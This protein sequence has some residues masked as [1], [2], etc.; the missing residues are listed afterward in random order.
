[1]HPTSK[2]LPSPLHTILILKSFLI[3]TLLS[4]AFGLQA[5]KPWPLERAQL[6]YNGQSWIA[7]ANYIPARDINTLE[8]WQKKTFSTKVVDKEFK[9]A[10]DIGFNTMRV[11]LAYIPWKENPAAFYKR[12]DKFLAI[13]AEHYIR[14]IFVLFD[15]CWD[16]NPKPGRQPKPRPGVHNS[17]W[18]QCPGKYILGDTAR[19]ALLKPYVEGVIRHFRNDDRILMWDLYNEPGNTNANSYGDT[20]LKNKPAYSLILLK[21]VFG[22]ARDSKPTQPLTAGIWQSSDGNLDELSPIDSCSFA[23]S[24]I[25]TFHC[26]SDTTGTERLVRGLRKSGRPMVCTEYMAR[27]VGSTFEDVMP[28]LK[29][30]NVG[31]I[32]WGFVSGKSQTIYPWDSW[33]NAY[34]NEPAVWFHDIFRSNLKPYNQKETDFIRCLIK[35]T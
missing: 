28:L 25:L 23:N 17:G 30:F 24:D 22:W 32:N 1:M 35:G 6:W 31:A 33:T 26:Y 7:G 5:Q 12:M 27:P 20:E 16:P 18:V 4:L 3:L 21:K 34:P 10:N 2:S 8:M 15:D 11:F 9:L 14:P 13:C 19:Y 29:S